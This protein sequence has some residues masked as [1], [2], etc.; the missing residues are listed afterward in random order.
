MWNDSI[1]SET[2]SVHV[3]H[4][5]D[6]ACWYMWHICDMA[7][8]VICAISHTSYVHICHICWYMLTHGKRSSAH[9]RQQVIGMF[10][11]MSRRST[12]NSH[13]NQKA[14]HMRWFKTVMHMCFTYWIHMWFTCSSHVQ[15]SDL[16]VV[17]MLNSHVI[18]MLVIQHVNYTWIA[19]NHMW[20]ASSI[21]PNKLWSANCAGFW[22][23]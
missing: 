12:F 20:I 10:F 18:D 5:C 9:T 7:R 22:L 4:M 16:H 15:Q 17:H 19:S 3:R 1:I 6:M 11:Q 14:M 13:A 23:I 21:V 2:W 8:E